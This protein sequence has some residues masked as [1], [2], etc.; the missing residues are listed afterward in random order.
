MTDAMQV[1]VENP[2]HAAILMD[3]DGTLSE[4][5]DHPDDAMP[6]ADVAP[7][8][9]RLAAAGATVGIVSGRPVEFLRRAL[10][11]AGLCFVGQYGLERWDGHRVVV[12]DEVEPFI[13]PVA[14][15]AT[16]ADAELP[17]VFVERKGVCAVTLHWRM[18]PGLGAATQVWADRAATRHGLSIY[19]TKMAVELRPPLPIDKGNGVER[20][21]AG[22]RSAVFAGDDHGDL[23]GFDALDRMVATGALDVAVRV[24]V[25]SAEEPAE[26]VERAD[27]LVNGPAGLTAWLRE[28]A[29]SISA[30]S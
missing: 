2:R 1:L 5:V 21:A 16:A 12:R 4:I 19:P 30:R 11:V 7:L 29:D 23:S 24:A 20:L 25:R 10:P 27:V 8:L 26:L 9:G 17:G 13:A 18:D 22:M 3:F 14:A 6:R 15:V 28:L